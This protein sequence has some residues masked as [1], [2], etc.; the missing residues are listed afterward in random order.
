MIEIGIDVGGTFTDVVL[1]DRVAGRLEVAKTASTPKDQSIG[2]LNG[3]DAPGCRSRD[4][5]AVRA[6]VDGRDQ[7]GARAQGRARRAPHHRGLPRPDR[8]RPHEPLPALFGSSSCGP[9][10]GRA[11]APLRG[12]RAPDRR[13]RACDAARTRPTS[14]RASTARAAA[15]AEAIA[16]C[17]LHAYLESGATR[18]GRPRSRARASARLPRHARPTSWPSTASSSASRPRCSTRTCSR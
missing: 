6:R 1:L 17:L 12:R 14:H 16:V 10:R 15:G 18:S 5:P 3:L 4:D 2:I 7:R 9:R 8:D 13:R 11:H